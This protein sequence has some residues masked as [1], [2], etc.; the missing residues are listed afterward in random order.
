MDDFLYL[1][2]VF[3][4]FSPLIIIF[5]LTPYISRRGT[6]FG[7][8]LMEDAQKSYK[9]KKI[10]RGYSVL[11]SLSGAI[12][13]WISVAFPSVSILGAAL[14]CYCAACLSLYFVCNNI[15]NNIIMGQNLENLQKEIN[16]H[17][18]SIKTKTFSISSW[19]YLFYLLPLAFI[20]YISLGGLYGYGAVL[21]LLSTAV[22][23]VMFFAHLITKNSKQYANKNTL[24]KSM[25]DNARFRKVWSVFI[26]FAGLVTQA[27]LIF[28]QLGFFGIIKS[29]ALT[30]ITP[31]ALTL[32]ITGASVYIAVRFNNKN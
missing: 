10:K 17:Y 4:S 15:L 5:T 31:F 24:E 28:M 20:W 12:F 1:I 3:C 22:S 8:M 23:L 16:I 6:C 11:V 19:W 30:V 14:V 13:V 21:P 32:F 18:I 26:F 27:M 2:A 9:I 7:V 29:K 25:E